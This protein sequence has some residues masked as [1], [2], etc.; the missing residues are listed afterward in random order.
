[1]IF[2]IKYGNDT[3]CY[4]FFKGKL[5][6]NKENQLNLSIVITNLINIDE[7]RQ[8]ERDTYI[9][10]R[11]LSTVEQTRLQCVRDRPQPVVSVDILYRCVTHSH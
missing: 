6:R 11:S 8:A 3:T 5:K 2:D 1:M 9:R 4:I 10:D 7:T